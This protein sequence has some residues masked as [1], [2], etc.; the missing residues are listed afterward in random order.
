MTGKHCDAPATGTCL[1]SLH[2]TLRYEAEEGKWNNF[3]TAFAFS[4]DEFPGFTFFG[5]V[6]LGGDSQDSIQVTTDVPRNGKYQVVLKYLLVNGSSDA[7]AKVL[8][9]DTVGRQTSEID[10][11]SGNGTSYSASGEFSLAAGMWEVTVVYTGSSRLLV[12][13]VILLPEVYYRPTILE[14]PVPDICTVGVQHEKCQLYT[15]PSL[16]LYASQSAITGTSSPTPFAGKLMAPIT[17]RFRNIILVFNGLDTIGF[18]ALI[19]SY[20]SQL[21]HSQQL[22]VIVESEVSDGGVLNL[23]PCTYT[24]GCREVA[25]LAG[26]VVEFAVR[27]SGE[28]VVTLSLPVGDEISNSLFIEHVHLVPVT[29]W[30]ATLIIP[31]FYCYYDTDGC[32]PTEYSSLSVVGGSFVYAGDEGYFFNAAGERENIPVSSDAELNRLSGSSRGAALL[33][34]SHTEMHMDL[35]VSASDDFYTVIQYHNPG[36]FTHV[37]TV[38]LDG[39]QFELPLSYCPDKSGCRVT[40]EVMARIDISSVTI[41]VMLHG[42]DMLYILSAAIIPR[43]EYEGRE[44]TRPFAVNLNDKFISECAANEFNIVDSIS[45]AFC[46]GSALSLSA[47]FHNGSLDCSCD[48]QGSVSSL[49]DSSTCGCQCKPNIVGER[50]T[51]CRIGYYGFPDCKPCEC[52]GGGI[53]DD[54]SGQCRC[55]PNVRGQNCDRC[56]QKFYDLRPI[57]G[58][59]ACDCHP[60]RSSNLKCNRRT[61]QCKCKEKFS[62]RQCDECI[63]GKYMPPRCKDCECDPRGSIGSSCDQMSGQC[64]CKGNMNGRTCSECR[65]GTF[66]YSLSNPDGCQLCNCDRLGSVG[67]GCHNVTG[68]C[69]CKSGVIG[70]KCNQ[71]APN[72]YRLPNGPCTDCDCHP[73]GSSSSA[74]DVRN[75]KCPCRRFVRGRQCARCLRG[76]Y[77]LSLDGCRACECS[78]FGSSGTDCDVITGQ[79]V[80][81][82]GTFGRRCDQ[83][84]SRH[85]VGPDGCRPCGNCTDSL[86]DLLEMLIGQ[87]ND[88][89]KNLTN[90][91]VLVNAWN[92]LRAMR[93]QYNQTRDALLIILGNLRNVDIAINGLFARISTVTSD[94]EKVDLHINSSVTWAL[95]VNKNTTES[96]TDADDLLQTATTLLGRLNGVINS[97]RLLRERLDANVSNIADITAEAQRILNEILDRD[98]NTVQ[99]AALDAGVQANVT[100]EIA[101]EFQIE[102]AV[103]INRTTTLQQRLTDYILLLSEANNLADMA[104]SNV[105][106]TNSLLDDV[107]SNLTDVQIWLTKLEIEASDINSNLSGTQQLISHA[108]QA[109]ENATDAYNAAKNISRILDIE[110]AAI[111]RAVYGYRQNVAEVGPSVLTAVKHS[112]T[113]HRHSNTLKRLFNKVK[114]EAEGPMAKY[115]AYHCDNI[116]A[117]VENATRYTVV[118]CRESHC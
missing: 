18:Y 114:S 35:A 64:S 83:C 26:E 73:N 60:V 57:R 45:S 20:Y 108:E 76:Y 40:S 79:C 54:V 8:V 109:I 101:E 77:E 52:I 117:I 68:Q 116:T 16:D 70:L 63:S 98:F 88:T 39:V 36:A 118:V 115:H 24:F 48:A 65:I 80:C 110:I 2:T 89:N 97:L 58:C 13:H 50:C 92:R 47:F 75:G 104:I 55:P 53:C 51:R 84:A 61:G 99:L 31:A 90:F 85:V 94:A 81:K 10:L 102:G 96:K 14:T 107:S 3:K 87:L 69:Q 41:S 74:C 33:N 62:G 82:S 21:N 15:Y 4:E 30:T 19:I 42:N 59:I 12:D 29:S 66:N 103:F 111:S 6:I 105:T 38:E 86:M 7:T 27:G 78:Q 93:E 43:S 91:T 34:A 37:I 25:T 100:L 71:C 46:A 67:E 32:I 23:L 95:T 11:K 22:E 106:T 5:Y 56:E 112:R 44:Y 1:P 72:T 49:C 9:N 28:A 113:I 17:S